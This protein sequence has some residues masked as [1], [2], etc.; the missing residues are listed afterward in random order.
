[1]ANRRS[2]IILDDDADLREE[3]CAYLAADGHDVSATDD[4]NAIASSGFANVDVLVLD[5]AMP[6]IDGIDVLSDL[7]QM[8]TA[9]RIVLIS[10]HGEPVLRTVSHSADAKGLT[11]LGVLAKPIDPVGLSAIVGGDFIAARHPRANGAEDLAPAL[12]QALNE[13]TLGVYFQPKVATTTLDFAGAEA[14]LSGDLGN[15]YRASPPDIV[16]A[17]R[18]VPGG[19]VSLTHAV[20]REAARACRTWTAAGFAHPVSVNLPIEVQLEPASVATL[21]RIVRDAGAETSQVTFELLEDTLYDSSA[22][23]LAVL[24][25]L[26]LAGFGLALDDVGQRQSGLLQLSNLPVTEIKIDTEIIL[27]ARTWE[28]ARE[29]FGSLAGLGSR[30]GILVVAEGVETPADLDFVRG[31]PVDYIQGYLISPKIPLED[32]LDRLSLQFSESFGSTT[33][34]RGND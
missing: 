4:Y 16:A 9:P 34:A 6:N 30:L 24:A 31:Y 20:L 1:M 28:K 14:L 18:N 25:K 15:G 5:L 22:D 33:I 10:G 2:V 19:V 27:Q 3:I 26:R 8:A 13:E 11:I 32:L 7:A 29:I 21:T 23:A 17:A 12:I